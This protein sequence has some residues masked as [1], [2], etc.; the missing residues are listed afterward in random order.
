M[1]RG[2][3]NPTARFLEWLLLSLVG[4]TLLTLAAAHAPARIKLLGLFAVGYGALAGWG[5]ARLA[6]IVGGI[7]RTTVLAASVLLL[8][9]GQVG[10]A[11]ESHRLYAA[12]ERQRFENA[13]A[14]VLPQLLKGTGRVGTADSGT[15][16]NAARKLAS[17]VQRD[18]QRA[19]ARRTRFDAYLT[20]RISALGD[21]S[22][23]WPGIVWGAEVL[24]GTI[25][26]TGLAA[27]ML[28][29]NSRGPGV[30]ETTSA[31][32]S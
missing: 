29:A 21:W 22:A 14:P 6:E 19:L 15:R 24:L 4:L 3:G 32:L 25:A 11:W 20:Y 8:I 1:T 18:R 31:S 26:G 10:L 13:A 30:E 12:R 5:L 17:S 9:G 16:V 27:R 23:P 7:G 2:H 28:R